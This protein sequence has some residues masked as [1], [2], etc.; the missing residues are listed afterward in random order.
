MTRA[1]MLFATLAAATTLT[2]CTMLGGY[3][4]LSVGYGDGYYDDYYDGGYYDSYYGWYD[5]FYYPGTG[6][7][8]YD[9]GGKRHGWSDAQRRYW[10]ARRAAIRDKRELRENW[11]DYRRER[12]QDQR[13]DRREDR[14][15]WRGE[16]RDDRQEGRDV[17][18]E[19]R[20]D[21]PTLPPAARQEQRAARQEQRAVRQEQRV[22]RQEQ[23]QESRDIRGVREAAG[24]VRED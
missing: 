1:R 13:A 23:R 12:R 16:R 8:V 10:E 11:A 5:D 7:Y 4:G 15:E 22:I 20:A 18:R 9:R 19:R 24:P 2:G 3:G 21:T 6:Y 14:R 17:R